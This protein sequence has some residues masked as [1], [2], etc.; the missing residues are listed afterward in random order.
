M[1][2]Q[3]LVPTSTHGS[4]AD[5]NIDEE[6]QSLRPP[7]A[8]DKTMR[9]FQRTRWSSLDTAQG[10]MSV[11][12]NFPRGGSHPLSL[13]SATS[14][15]LSPGSTEAQKH[16]LSVWALER[17]ALCTTGIRGFAECC[18]FCRVPFVGHSAKKALPSAALGKVRLSAQ[19][20][21][22]EFWTLGKD[23]FAE[24]HTLGKGAL[25]KGPSTAVPKLTAVSLCRE[26]K[27]G[28]RQRVFFAECL[29]ANTRQSFLCRVSYLDTRQSI[30]LFF[31]FCLPNFLWYVPTLCRPTCIICGQL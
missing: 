20:P 14:S 24:C 12:W 21:F 28:T 19:S 11:I 30:F 3:G 5:F 29:K 8:P 23:K 13:L 2:A 4:A 9:A 18:I 15:R 1:R 22:T 25:G 10:P 27:S 26:P 6:S 31:W 17:L 7:I 16:R